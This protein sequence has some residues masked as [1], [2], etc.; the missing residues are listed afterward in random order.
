MEV[1]SLKDREILRSL[2]KRKLELAN[3]ARNDE[4]LKMWQDLANGV[5]SKPTVRLLFSNFPHE[6]VTPRLCCEGEGARAIEKSL[7]SSMV[8]RELFDDDTPISDRFEVAIFKSAYPFKARPNI[9]KANGSGGYHINPI[10]DD[11]EADIQMF[12]GGTFS[13]DLPATQKYCDSVT[14]MWE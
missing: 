10:T 3:N 4:I 8:G 7:L 12:L 5:R 13:T 1:I 6:V 2:A 9:Q 11:I 14:K